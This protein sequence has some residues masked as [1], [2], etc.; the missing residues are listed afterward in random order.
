[1]KTVRD[2]K[3]IF[4]KSGGKQSVFFTDFIY[5]ILKVQTTRESNYFNSGPSYQHFSLSEYVISTKIIRPL[6][7]YLSHFSFNIALEV[8]S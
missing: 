6:S 7:P 3:Y 8:R 4:Y 1:M 2:I 5:I